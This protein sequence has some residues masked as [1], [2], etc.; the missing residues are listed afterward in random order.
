MK[1][2]EFISLLPL[3][4]ERLIVRKVSLKDIDLLM[5]LDKQ[6]I[7]Q[8]YLGGIK[9]RTKEERINFINKKLNH[10]KEGYSS[11]LTVCLKD[12]TPIGFSQL[13]INEEKNNAEISYI[14]DYN[15]CNNGYC[16]E[17]CTKLI[18]VAF[19]NLNLDSI[20]A[21]T[22]NKNE[23]SIKVLTN[24]G[25]KQIGNYSKTNQIETLI[26]QEYLL[27]SSSYNK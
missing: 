9:N 5:K 24:L 8:K 17:T 2:K 16:T 12:G 21:D 20:Y 3:S 1:N 4:T 7:T 25:F 27:K 13:K 22:I 23:K 6:E 14:F 15:Y 10:F 11:M 19:N 26:F 18:D